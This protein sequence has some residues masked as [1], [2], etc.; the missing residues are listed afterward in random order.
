MNSAEDLAKLKRNQVRVASDLGHEILALGGSEREISQII[1][2]ITTL[3]MLL[4]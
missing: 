4:L 2:R 3:K 1:F